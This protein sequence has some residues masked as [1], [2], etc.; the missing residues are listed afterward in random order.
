MKLSEIDD[1]NL[2][3]QDIADIVYSNIEILLHNRAGVI[4]NKIELAKI[5]SPLILEGKKSKLYLF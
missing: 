1:T 3:D 2:T 4:S 5:Y